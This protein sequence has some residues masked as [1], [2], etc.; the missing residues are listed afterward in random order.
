M[1]VPIDWLLWWVY[2]IAHIYMIECLL[3]WSRTIVV[4]VVVEVLVVHLFNCPCLRALNLLLCSLI[5]KQIKNDILSVFYGSIIGLTIRSLLTL[6]SKLCVVGGPLFGNAFDG[7]SSYDLYCPYC[8]S[9]VAYRRFRNALG[10]NSHSPKLERTRTLNCLHST[11]IEK[12]IAAMKVGMCLGQAHK[13]TY[14]AKPPTKIID[15]YTRRTWY[16]T[17]KPQKWNTATA[18][19]DWM[20][21]NRQLSIC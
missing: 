12:L 6:I 18:K 16:R 17:W 8:V 20:Q 13:H 3:I 9:A 15:K 7:H 5:S 19:L 1:P 21:Q 14:K 2:T 4:F 10:P 11:K